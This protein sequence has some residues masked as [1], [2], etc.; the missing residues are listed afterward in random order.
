[1]FGTTLVL[2]PH[3]DDGI[4]GAGGTIARCLDDG[5][6]VHLAVFSTTKASHLEHLPEDVLE[7]EVREAART[8]GLTGERLHVMDFPL[9]H[10]PE[11]RQEV[12]R[13]L[14]DLRDEIEPD[15]LLGPAPSDAHQDHQVLADEGS[16]V[17]RDRTVL[18][19]ETPW[20]QTA[21]P[22]SC[23][24][25]LEEEHVNRKVKAFRAYKSLEHRSFIDADLLRGTA[26]SRGSQV[27]GRWAEAFQVLRWVPG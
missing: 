20:N 14:E 13:R 3:T 26:R 2:S 17:F 11:R 21:F 6:E 27:R 5:N 19:Y 4:L 8:L 12:L 1:M 7:T 24:V 16:R 22:T 25:P 15:V 23:F 10:F 9:R 18:A